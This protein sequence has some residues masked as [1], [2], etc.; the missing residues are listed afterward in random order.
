[1]CWRAGFFAFA[2][3]IAVF[4]LGMANVAGFYALQ[5]SVGAVL[6]AERVVY[7]SSVATLGRIF[8][9]ESSDSGSIDPSR[10]T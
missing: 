4:G 9:T 10:W 8:G 2:A 1:M 3:L 7:T 6:A 5:A